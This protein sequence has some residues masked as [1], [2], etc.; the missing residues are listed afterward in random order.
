MKADNKIG[1]V[2]KA[3][4]IFCSIIEISWM[5]TKSRRKNTVFLQE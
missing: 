5:I 3:R 2:Y 1:T 4:Q